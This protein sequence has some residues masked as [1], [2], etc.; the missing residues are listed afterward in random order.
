MVGI[1][2]SLHGI[3]M[4]QDFFFSRVEKICSFNNL[5]QKKKLA[6]VMVSV[7]YM[8]NTPRIYREKKIPTKLA[9]PVAERFCALNW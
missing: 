4:M 3:Y 9:P 5:R 8:N 1:N 2:T 6:L 7:F